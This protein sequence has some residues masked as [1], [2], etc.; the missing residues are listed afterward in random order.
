METYQVIIEENIWHY[1]EALRINNIVSRLIPESLDLRY[2][3]R[4]LSKWEGTKPIVGKIYTRRFNHEK[5]EL[6]DTLLIVGFDAEPIISLEFDPKV[7]SKNG[8]ETAL[9]LC[10]I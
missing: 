10:S 7:L 4:E 9:Y 8:I 6:T 2:D 5:G 1:D 3:I